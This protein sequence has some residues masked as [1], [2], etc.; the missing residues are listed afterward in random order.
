MAMSMRYRRSPWLLEAD[1]ASELHRR[2]LA[3]ERRKNRRPDRVKTRMIGK[4]ELLVNG[5]RDESAVA[6]YLSRSKNAERRISAK[7]LHKVRRDWNR[8]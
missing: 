2:E 1:I 7:T 4:G 5:I 8:K 6:T 3:S